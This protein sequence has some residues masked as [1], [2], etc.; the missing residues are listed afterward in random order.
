VTEFATHA[1]VRRT[2][3]GC[4][5][6]I[7]SSSLVRRAVQGSDDDYSTTSP[8][9]TSS[10]RNRLHFLVRPASQAEHLPTELPEPKDLLI[11]AVRTECT[12]NRVYLQQSV[13]RYRV[14]LATDCTCHRVYPATECTLQTVYLATQCTLQHSVPCN[15]VYPATECTL[16][17][18][19]PCNRVY[20]ATQCTLQ[21][22]VPRYRVYPYRPCNTVYP[23]HTTISTIVTTYGIR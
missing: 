1:L 17:H 15:T 13:P 21:Q 6:R 16:Q 2:A 18:S 3:Q 10:G 7:L 23:L 14:Y 8:D 20:L 5:N 9:E 4:D 22:S 19:V 11:V 12:C